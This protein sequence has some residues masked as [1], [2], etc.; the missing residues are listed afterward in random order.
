M[1]TIIAAAA[2][3]V[4]LAALL[5]A[6]GYAFSKIYPALGGKKRPK[7]QAESRREAEFRRQLSNLW[8]YDGGEQEEFGHEQ[9]G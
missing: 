3:L 2:L 5:F 4:S 9:N 7:P 6:G 8:H 1:E